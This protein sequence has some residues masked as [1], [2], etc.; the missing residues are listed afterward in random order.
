MIDPVIIYT[1]G[2]AINKK[3]GKGA[4]EGG[5]GVVMLYKNYRR[6]IAKGK[7]INTTSAR[8]EIMAII[9]AM[10][11]INQPNKHEL[12]IHTDNQYCS[13]T[14]NKGWYDNW[15]KSGNIEER[16]NYDLWIRFFKVYDELGGRKKITLKWIK[17]H[18]GHPLNERADVLANAG[19]LKEKVLEDHNEFTK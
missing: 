3:T 19:R 17:G 7:Y 13:N 14:V 5:A 4:R 1:D 12:I 16:K 10:E 8:M 18:A 9:V 15:K 11:A 2:S 6:E